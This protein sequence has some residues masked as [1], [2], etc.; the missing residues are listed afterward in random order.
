[1]VPGDE[2]SKSI[3]VEITPEDKEYAKKYASQ[4]TRFD[5]HT[6]FIGKLGERCVI[7]YLRKQGVRLSDDRTEVDRADQYDI[8]TTSDIIDVKT[9]S[10]PH[11]NRLLVP[12]D[13]FD[14]GRKFSFYI[15]VKLD[16]NLEKA[17]ICGYA[18][19]RDIEDAAVMKLWEGKEAYWIN[20]DN[21]RPFKELV[22]YLKESR[23]VR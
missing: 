1:M 18:T 9:T 21:L 13:S 7:R 6:F 10:K 4:S 8:G 17:K 11:N 16:E 20:Y 15:A 5:H 12:K 2:N 23:G 19:K 22:E 14:G 3:T